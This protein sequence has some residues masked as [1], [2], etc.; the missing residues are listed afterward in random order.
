MARCSADLGT[1][2][3]PDDRRYGFNSNLTRLKADVIG[4]KKILALIDYQMPA[5][6]FPANYDMP[7]GW[8][9]PAWGKWQLRDVY[10]VSVTKLDGSG[11]HCLGKRVIYV[12]KAT[13]APLW[14]DLY[15][16]SMQPWRF[17]GI[18]PRALDVPGIGPRIPRTRWSTAS[19]T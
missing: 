6:R 11:G 13:Y 18:F 17:V 10:V 12:D 16:E 7:L 15:D 19:G 3:T 2:E 9:M 4:E 1:D 8:P 14:E 5:G